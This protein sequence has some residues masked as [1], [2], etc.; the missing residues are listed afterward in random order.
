MSL[1]LGVACM[2]YSHQHNVSQLFLFHGRCP[3]Q[4]FN[5]FT[6]FS[7]QSIVTMKPHL[8]LVVTCDATTHGTGFLQ[9][10]GLVHWVL[11]DMADTL[12]KTFQNVFSRK[13]ST[14]DWFKLHL[15]LF[16]RAQLTTNQDWVRWWLSTEQ[17][18]S[19]FLHQWW[20]KIM[21]NNLRF[22]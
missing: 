15:I 4:S 14:E 3:R 19:Y 9:L 21:D 13:I 16:Q 22:V 10:V 12:P 11:C 20:H 5:R 2:S 8:I 17:F 7:H 6:A 1:Y 18:T